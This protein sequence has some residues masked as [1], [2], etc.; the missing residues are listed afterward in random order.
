MI[1]A[2]DSWA[3]I[4]FKLLAKMFS[5][6]TFNLW[7]CKVRQILSSASQGLRGPGDWEPVSDRILW[8]CTP[9]SV[10]TQPPRCP[11]HLP[12]LT[13]PKVHCW[14]S[15]SIFSDGEG[16]GV[17]EPPHSA[18]WQWPLWIAPRLGPACQAEGGSPGS[19]PGLWTVQFSPHT[20]QS[21]HRTQS[22]VIQW[23]P[24]HIL[25]HFSVIRAPKWV[26]GASKWREE[27]D[28]ASW[29]EGSSQW[30]G[31]QPQNWKIS[32]TGT[33][34]LAGSEVPP[35]LTARTQTCRYVATRED[36]DM[37]G[38]RGW[39]RPGAKLC[40]WLVSATVNGSL[41]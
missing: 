10:H 29:A 18:T 23:L 9:A 19:W 12:V 41:K 17:P 39:A 37:C 25:W 6:P 14:F 15:S 11:S 27:P 20:V 38:T 40:K 35:A 3:L 1:S 26:R 22:T 8:M 33:G 13:H 24:G 7:S 28:P 30:R 31:R 34:E 4:D 36:M 5:P 2:N 21:T 16:G 32:T